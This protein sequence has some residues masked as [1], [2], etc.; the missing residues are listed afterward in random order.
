MLGQPSFLYKPDVFLTFLSFPVRRFLMKLNNE[1]VTV[2]LKNGTIV[3]GTI[4]G[5]D[6]SMNTYLK[7]V[8][9]TLKGSLFTMLRFMVTEDSASAL[10]ANCGDAKGP[11][12]T[13]QRVTGPVCQ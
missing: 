11:F 5:V 6:M 1:T 9:M 4:A 12:I 3:H 2:E 7:N 13:P 8:K 10:K